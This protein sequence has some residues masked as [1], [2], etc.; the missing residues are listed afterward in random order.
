[1]RRDSRP[2]SAVEIRWPRMRPYTLS[3][4]ASSSRYTGR[5]ESAQSSARAGEARISSAIARVFMGIV[6]P[7]E[8]GNMANLRY[9]RV[10][11]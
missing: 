8:R 4:S 6:W 2:G 5:A 7:V 1:M 3:A 10:K 11:I 9:G